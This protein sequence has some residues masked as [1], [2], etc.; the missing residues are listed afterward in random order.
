[1]LCRQSLRDQAINEVA[2]AEAFLHQGSRLALQN[3]FVSLRV[4]ADTI[5]LTVLQSAPP[6]MN[7]L[8]STDIVFAPL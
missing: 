3:A 2:A 8:Q 1:M 5:N 7:H 4:F 6:V